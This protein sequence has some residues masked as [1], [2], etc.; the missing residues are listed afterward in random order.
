MK[1][2]LTMVFCAV[3]VFSLCDFVLKCALIGKDFTIYRFCGNL[4]TN[5]QCNE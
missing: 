1:T 4:K 5:A 2:N 3:T